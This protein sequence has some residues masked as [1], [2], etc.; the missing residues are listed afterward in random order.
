MNKLLKTF[1]LALFLAN[2]SW[3]ASEQRMLT[4]NEE[5]IL[6]V[7]GTGRSLAMLSALILPIPGILFAMGTDPAESDADLREISNILAKG[8]NIDYQ[9]YAG[10]TALIYAAYYGYP[11]IAQYLV[12]RG[13][14]KNIVE[15]DGYTALTMAQY[16]VDKY[17]RL[18]KVNDKAD[19]V[20]FYEEKIL[21]YEQTVQAL[22]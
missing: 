1:M 6:A 7:T 20:Q 8:A 22:R 5:L 17:K 15:K 21:R 12:Y 14:N 4:P 16:Y 11:K 18:L 13:A 2:V 10:Y 9:D 19:M 3:A